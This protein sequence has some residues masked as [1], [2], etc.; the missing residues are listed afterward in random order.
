VEAPSWFR[1]Q[2][3]YN[4]IYKG[5]VLEWYMRV[6]V[7]LEKDYAL[8]HELLPRKGKLLDIGCGYGFMVY[9]LYWAS[10]NKRQITGVDYDEE[11]IETANHCFGK[12]D[13]LQFVHADIAHFELE[14]YNGITIMDVLHYLKPEEQMSVIEKA[15][16][17]LL[18]GGILIIRDGDADLKQKHKGTQLTE[19]FSTKIFSFNKTVNDLYFLSG[20]M[21]EKLAI[22]HKLAIERI[23]DTRF[24]SNVVWVLKKS[25]E[26]A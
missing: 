12:T 18:P 8:F 17:A 5:P 24:T 22:K 25:N 4:Y 11:K 2:L 6:K 15:I 9:I 3:F 26:T 13:D 10:Q 21:V 19:L 23:D 20:Q 1:E 7:R 16:D 14:K